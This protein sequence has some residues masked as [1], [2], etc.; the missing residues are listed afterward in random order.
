MNLY[1]KDKFHPHIYAGI[2][3]VRSR[4]SESRIMDFCEEMKEY[5]EKNYTVL[6]D[7][8]IDHGDEVLADGTVDLDRFKINKLYAWMQKDYVQVIFIRNLN[9]ITTNIDD[10]QYFLI[11]AEKL[12]VAVHS[13]DAGIIL[14][15]GGEFDI[16]DI[17]V[18]WDGGSGC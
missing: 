5:A 12:G 10:Q 4:K 8:V 16:P 7:I 14:K 17:M 13:M 6:L 9:E 1:R 3:F 11:C 2:G 18:I 15:T